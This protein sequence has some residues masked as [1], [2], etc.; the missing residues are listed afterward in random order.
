MQEAE[1]EL[2]EECKFQVE[3]ITAWILENRCIPAFLI[4]FILCI[5]PLKVKQELEGVI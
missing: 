5:T 1:R 2:T 3:L 4:S